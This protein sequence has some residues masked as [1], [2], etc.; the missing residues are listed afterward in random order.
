MLRTFIFDKAKSHW[1]EEEHS[2][3]LNDICII[4][5]EEKECIYLWKGPKSSKKRYQEGYNHIKELINNF[6]D[7]NLQFILAKKTFPLEIQK[8][9]DSLLENKDSS[10]LLFNRF[11]TIRLY[12]TFLLLVI[13]IPIIS[14]LNLSSSLLWPISNGIY[15]IDNKTFEIWI[16]F[17]EI[18]TLVAIIF[19]IFNTIIGIVELENQVIIFSIV[20]VILN[21]GLI[22]YYNFGIYLFWFEEGSTFT[23]FLIQ[24][25]D[26]ITFLLIN[27]I[28]VL[29]FEIPNIFKL[30]S[31]LKSYRK[32]IFF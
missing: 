6:P 7:L 31:F 28:S 30:I 22:L 20:G 32:F 3:L 9:L 23:L 10:N 16:N 19:F 8:K 21:V 11:I 1:V 18:L 12:F 2:L 14:L 4:L 27:I 5:D 13:F 24:K 17:S 29:I 25:N 26:I 15:E